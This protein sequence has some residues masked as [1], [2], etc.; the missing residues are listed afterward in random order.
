MSIVE[1][2]GFKAKRVVVGSGGGFVSKEIKASRPTL[3]E[4]PYTLESAR[5]D[6]YPVFMAQ[7]LLHY[8]FEISKSGNVAD[9][10]FGLV[11]GWYN[12]DPNRQISWVEL[13]YVIDTPPGIS[14][15]P[16]RVGVTHQE[17]S[18]MAKAFDEVKKL[19]LYE[20]EVLAGWW[21]S[22]PNL[23]IFYSQTDKNTQREIWRAPWQIGIVV[24]PI[25]NDFG[26][27]Q[28]P[29]SKRSIPN[30]IITDSWQ[31]PNQKMPTEGPL[32]LPYKQSIVNV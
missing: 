16:T 4:F 9:E 7:G 26:V 30:I 1:G 6:E 21:H 3:R 22:H 27:F 5:K 23:G 15:G 28:G 31:I 11:L 13:N 32:L 8:I 17:R 2:S 14:S 12:Q 25:R 20:G 24:D 18:Q 10:H 29:E 19:P